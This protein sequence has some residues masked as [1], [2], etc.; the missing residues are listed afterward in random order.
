MKATIKDM[1]SNQFRDAEEY[2]YHLEQ[3]QNYM[4]NQVVWESRQEDLKRL[5]PD[6]LVFYDPQMNPNEPP[7]KVRDDLK[8]E[9][10]EVRSI[11]GK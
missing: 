9:I 2:A 7:R 1:R 11:T 8:V 10:V 5:K 4:E 3:A 6:A